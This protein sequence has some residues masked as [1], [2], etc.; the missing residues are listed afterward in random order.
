[1][2]VGKYDIKNAWKVP[3]HPEVLR[4]PHVPISPAHAKAKAFTELIRGHVYEI[5]QV[6]GMSE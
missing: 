1:M 4:N 3:I 5:S 2:A 6:S